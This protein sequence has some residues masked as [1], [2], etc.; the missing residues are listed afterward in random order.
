[1]TPEFQSLAWICE[2]AEDRKNKTISV[3]LLR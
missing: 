1:M 3:E 2:N